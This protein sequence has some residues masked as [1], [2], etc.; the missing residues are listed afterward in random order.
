MFRCPV[1]ALS[2]YAAASRCQ[3][4]YEKTPEDEY[5]DEYEDDDEDDDEDV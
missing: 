5:E 2:S 3:R 1:F 4:A